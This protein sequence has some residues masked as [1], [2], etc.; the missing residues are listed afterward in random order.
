LHDRRWPA[1]ARFRSDQT[2]LE[3]LV[4]TRF[5][6]ANRYPLRSKPL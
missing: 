2:G 6:A 1:K 3:I 5:L 4:L